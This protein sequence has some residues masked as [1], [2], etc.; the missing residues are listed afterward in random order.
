MKPIG[1][2]RR[3]AAIVVITM[4]L[5]SFFEPLI[6]TRPP[7]M[8]KKEWS[9][10][11]IVHQLEKGRLRTSVDN[12]VIPSIV[13]G[14]PYILMLFALMSLCFFP[15]QNVLA[16]VGIIG[17]IASCLILRFGDMD[18]ERIFYGR[19]CLFPGPVNHYKLA[20]VLLI[21]MILLTLLS[22]SDEPKYPTRLGEGRMRWRLKP[23]K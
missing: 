8:G 4:G 21:V 10:L 6:I 17:T 13:F 5:F 7:I 19:C 20:S 2:K 15:I 22:R 9:G 3:A 1:K 14:L 18:L 16:A 12:L 11:D 23:L